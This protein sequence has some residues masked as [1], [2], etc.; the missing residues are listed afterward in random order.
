MARITRARM[1]S[2]ADY[3][4]NAAAPRADAAAADGERAAADPNESQ[5]TRQCAA[6]AAAIARRNATEYR[7]IANT[8]RA[9]E[10]PDGYEFD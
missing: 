1:N 2:D 4:Q 7:H 10:I 3:W 6:R 9:G 5:Y 8:L